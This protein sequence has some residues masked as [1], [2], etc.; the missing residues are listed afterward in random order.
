MS[1]S[2]D[3]ITALYQEHAQ[4]LALL[5]K[6]GISVAQNLGVEFPSLDFD[7]A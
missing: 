1:K 2:A 5:E 7:G 3:Y 6:R 4:L